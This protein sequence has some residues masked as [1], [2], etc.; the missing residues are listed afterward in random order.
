MSFSSLLGMYGSLTHREFC[1]EKLKYEERLRNGGGI[2]NTKKVGEKI[3]KEFKK[4]FFHFR[5][6]TDYHR[7]ILRERYDFFSNIFD[8]IESDF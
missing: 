5:R 4:E 6:P 7:E 3:L 1:R 2:K 8:D